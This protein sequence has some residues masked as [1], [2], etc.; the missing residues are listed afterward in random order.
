LDSVAIAIAII[1]AL[2][3]VVGIFR[4]PAKADWWAQYN[5]YLQSADWK[6]KRKAILLRCAGRCERCGNYKPLTV[7]HIRYNRVPNEQPEDLAALCFDCHQVQHPNRR[8][9][10]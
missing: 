5:R 10:F 3:G 8:L 9:R 7:H 1:G 6:T 2:L 4:K